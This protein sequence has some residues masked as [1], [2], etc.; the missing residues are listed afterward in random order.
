MTEPVSIS[1]TTIAYDQYGQQTVSGTVTWSGLAYVGKVS[2][3]DREMLNQLAQ[4]WGGRDG[5]EFKYVATILLPFETPVKET[6]ILTVN[7]KQWAIVWQGND[8]QDTVQL[9]TK[10]I[11]RLKFYEDTQDV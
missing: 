6:D 8:T 10:L 11:V 4:Y 1:N 3:R 5:V 2:A 9:Y 7:N